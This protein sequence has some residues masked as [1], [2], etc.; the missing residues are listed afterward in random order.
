MRRTYTVHLHGGSGRKPKRDKKYVRA[1]SE[2]A[3]IAGAKAVSVVFRN[4]K[5]RGTAHEAC[6]T[7]DLNAKTKEQ[8]FAMFDE[9][10]GVSHG[11]R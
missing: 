7:G 3:A 6:P 4:G 11:S 1:S 8:V 2:E 5:C 9:M 10:R